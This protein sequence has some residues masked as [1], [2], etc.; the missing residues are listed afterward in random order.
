MKPNT[1]NEVA[2]ALIYA[3]HRLRN[4]ADARLRQCGLSLSSVKAMRA[5]EDSELS[6]R[7]ISEALHVAPRTVTDLIDGLEARGLVA[8][9]PHP[10][11]RRITLL[12][13]T[14]AGRKQLVAASAWAE[15][16]YRSAFSGLSEKD[17]QT[18]RRL[19]DQVAPHD[20]S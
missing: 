16:T 20:L 13:L 19:L 2:D 4:A 9:E 6:M 5:L 3:A 10:A 11:D 12:H 17:Q 8:R 1:G 7:E 15:E 14:E 18:L